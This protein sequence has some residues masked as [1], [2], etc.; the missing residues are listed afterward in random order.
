MELNAD[1]SKRVLL[2][3][4][5]IDWVASPMAGVCRRML[6]R[7]GGEV[8]RATSVVRYDPGSRFSAHVHGG[9]EEFMVLEG[10]FQDEHG[11]FPAGSYIRNPPQSSHT[12]GSEEGCVILV[13]LWQFDADDR[14]QVRI[15]TNTS[16]MDEDPERPGVRVARLHA[17]RR[18]EVRLETWLPETRVEL[19]TG[20]GAEL[21]VLEGGFQTNSERLRRYSWLRIPRGDSLSATAG[22][23]GARIWIKTGHLRFAQPSSLG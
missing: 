10:V 7:I 3:T 23:Q 19:Q 1:F 4:D 12:P 21:F 8:A 22:S 16:S 2:H 11:D 14:T 13:K 20:G 15:D 5:E 9:G 17:D 18:E 6:D